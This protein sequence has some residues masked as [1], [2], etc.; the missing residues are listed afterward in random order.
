MISQKVLLWQIRNY[1]SV[2]NHYVPGFLLV[3]F[4][5]MSG[6]IKSKTI[7]NVQNKSAVYH[8]SDKF[9]KNLGAN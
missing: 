3:K 1:I 8:K 2:L 5:L 4:F 9:F 6:T 7:N